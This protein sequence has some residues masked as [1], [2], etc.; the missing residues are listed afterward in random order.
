MAT[1]LPFD[2]PSLALGQV[3]DTE[4]LECIDQIG[5]L[6]ADTDAAFGM[7]NSLLAMRRAL[8]MTTSELVGL[9]V[10]TRELLAR[11]EKVNGSVS[12]AAT[13]YARARM[14][15][16]SKILE[17]R[18]RLAGLA[19]ASSLESPI[20][21][22]QSSIT[23]LPLAAD[24][25]RMDV[26]YF[27][28]TREN[29]SS[30]S[31]AADVEAAVR[32]SSAALGSMAPQLAR[33]AASQV[34]R[35]VRN[36]DV[37]GTLVITATCS[38]RDILLFDPL[39]IDPDKAVALWNTRYGKTVWS[40]DTRD[41]AAMRLASATSAGDGHETAITVI[42]GATYGS[43]FVG[44][45]HFLNNSQYATQLSPAQAAN[46]EEQLRLGAWLQSTTGGVGIDHA[47]LDDVRRAL[48]SH[49]VSTHVDVVAMGAIP[50]IAS[51]QVGR[52][53]QA[54]VAMAPGTVSSTDG[55]FASPG[56]AQELAVAANRVAAERSRAHADLIQ[57]LDAIDQQSSKVLDLNSLMIA[58]DN[59]LELVKDNGG[60]A[61][62]PVGFYLKHITAAYIAT[63]W[64]AKYDADLSS[65]D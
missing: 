47:V 25:L 49:T 51:N 36:H 5:R 30:G 11:T 27:S 8:A 64:L 29:T 44:M 45:V 20:D 53:T 16:E 62:V 48:A 40:L 12:A 32:E 43:S 55:H 35:Q 14:T 28:T 1:V 22:E 26:Q 61:G 9:G 17:C 18:A 63:L 37:V 4:V 58:L 46:L 34:D 6:Q 13:S 41:V 56:H 23:R 39:I 65:T 15:N 50:R 2:H 19:P 52:A 59:Y 54:L 57:G 24:G 21:F 10:D 38:H 7:L 33:E 31:F 3:I 42:T 60:A